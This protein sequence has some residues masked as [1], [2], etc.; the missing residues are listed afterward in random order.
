M[1]TWQTVPFYYKQSI[2]ALITVTVLH[3]WQYH[4]IWIISFSAGNITIT[5][6]GRVSGK[7]ALMQ[8]V[9]SPGS[10]VKLW[11]RRALQ[12]NLSMWSVSESNVK[13]RCRRKSSCWVRKSH[14]GS[15]KPLIPAAFPLFISGFHHLMNCADNSNNSTC[16]NAFNENIKKKNEKKSSFSYIWAD[17]LNC[18]NIAGVIMTWI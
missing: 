3:R 4:L 8:G 18:R 11:W 2:L 13:A 17:Q 16:S 14:I 5:R 9:N 1:N 7:L 6:H 12:C 15:S 10:F